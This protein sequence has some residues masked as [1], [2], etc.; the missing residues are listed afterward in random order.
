ML[1]LVVGLGN[2]GRRYERTRHN[3]GFMVVDA[4]RAR[5]GEPEER[6]AAHSLLCR[7]TIGDREVALAKPLL[8]MNRSGRAVQ[9]LLAK[10]G[11]EVGE[12]LVVA[13]DFHL[14]FGV[15][16]VRREGSHGGHNGLRSII[17]SLGTQEFARLRIGIGAAP[18]GEDPAD[19]VLEKF[20]RDEATRL[21]DVVQEAADC[22]WRAVG[23]GMEKAMNRHNRR[24]GGASEAKAD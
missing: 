10:T 12:I 8:F 11:T 6:E 3:V 19:F 20:G 9:A 14:E 13:D 22:V 7:A 1:S 21:P 4:V 15:L 23:E 18:A 17:E 5:V 24:S 16:R 2:P